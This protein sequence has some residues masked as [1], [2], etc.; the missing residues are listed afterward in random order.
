MS[1]VDTKHSA[2]RPTDGM[3]ALAK[4]IADGRM[5]DSSQ[6]TTV[7]ASVYT[8]P[9]YWAREKAA[10]YDRLPQI[11]APSAL[12]PDPGMAVPHDATGRPLLIT[13]DGDGRARVFLN[14][15]RHRGCSPRS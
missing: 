13:R 5:R 1:D 3:L 10:I 4:D 6:A 8:D 11:L 15:C 14:V 12:L 2:R 7:P 9:G